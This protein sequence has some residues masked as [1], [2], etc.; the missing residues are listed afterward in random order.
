MSSITSVICY[1]FYNFIIFKSGLFT[2]LN[3]RFKVHIYMDLEL[4]V[5]ITFII[6]VLQGFRVST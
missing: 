2:V 5:N 1:Q 6:L 3:C 4:F